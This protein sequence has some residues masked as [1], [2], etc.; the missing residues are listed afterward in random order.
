MGSEDKRAQSAPGLE[1]PTYAGEDAAILAELP[2]GT[3]ERIG[4][5]FG[6]IKGLKA[7][8]PFLEIRG[9]PIPAGINDEIT[10]LEELFA[11]E[12][13][14]Y[15]GAGNGNKG[16]QAPENPTTA[17]AD[18]CNSDCAITAV[19]KSSDEVKRTDDDA[20]QDGASAQDQWAQDWSTT[21]SEDDEMAKNT[22]SYAHLK[23]ML[24]RAN[25][26]SNPESIAAVKG[27]ICA[28][29]N[30]RKFG[31]TLAVCPVPVCFEYGDMSGCF[32]CN[33]VE[34]DAD[35]CAMMKWVTPAALVTHLITNR[36]GL[37]PWNT[38]IDW[39]RLALDNYTLFSFPQTSQKQIKMTLID[40]FP[41]DQVNFK[42]LP[43]T[44]AYVK[45]SYI[46]E[47]QWN[48]FNL[49]SPYTD[50]LF[51][52]A[53]RK[54]LKQ[55][56]KKPAPGEKKK[57]PEQPLMENSQDLC[58]CRNMGEHAIFK[59]R[60]IARYI[61]K[62]QATKEDIKRLQAVQERARALSEMEV[63]KKM[64][65]QVTKEKMGRRKAKKAAAAAAATA[66]S[67][68]AEAEAEP[69]ASTASAE[70]GNA[71]AAAA[72]SDYGKRK[73]KAAAAAGPGDEKETNVKEEEGELYE[74]SDIEEEDEIPLSQRMMDLTEEMEELF[75]AYQKARN[76]VAGKY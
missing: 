23:G 14:K 68:D 9:I 75:M 61:P 73:G 67:A 38:R 1:Q 8:I 3:E 17:P 19:A 15:C 52:N 34:H 20:S 64:P 50:P 30:C 74:P 22:A 58:Y 21:G 41:V 5:L 46:P 16:G 28:N 65:K 39:I 7:S 33:V 35:D 27:P 49:I 10:T 63:A 42:S 36:D 70:T 51:T 57:F 76:I 62:M 32:F 2:L 24:H 48:N 72:P 66:A 29:P 44:R 59:N 56:V 69:A 37:P 25:T 11:V 4:Y 26:L 18:H 53:N 43:L 47:K 6:R 71:T 12:A 54:L 60:D 40:S 55:L 31:H 45:K 13:A